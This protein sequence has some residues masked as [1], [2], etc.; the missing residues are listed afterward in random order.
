MFIVNDGVDCFLLFQIS[1]ARSLSKDGFKEGLEN[2]Y[3]TQCSYNGWVAAHKWIKLHC[4][5]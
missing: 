4:I 3:G 2:A 5:L 1:V